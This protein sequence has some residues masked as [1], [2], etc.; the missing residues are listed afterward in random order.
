MPRGASREDTLELSDASLTVVP[1]SKKNMLKRS[2]E[3]KE[4]ERGDKVARP[5]LEFAGRIGL[6]SRGAVE[7][8][9]SRWTL[10]AF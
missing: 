4:K 7:L 3:E 10:C 1:K 5:R 9:D 6:R 8:S 2:G